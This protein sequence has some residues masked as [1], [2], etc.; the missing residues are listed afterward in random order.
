MK[1]EKRAQKG[2][3]FSPSYIAY[4]MKTNDPVKNI[5]KITEEVGCMS[6]NV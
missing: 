3:N 5:L 4:L 1:L 6:R 2:T